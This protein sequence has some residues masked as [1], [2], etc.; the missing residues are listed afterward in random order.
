MTFLTVSK[1]IQ[2]SIAFWVSL[3][4][5]L[6]VFNFFRYVQ[7]GKR[8]SNIRCILLCV[9]NFVLLEILLQHIEGEMYCKIVL[10]LWALLL[11]ILLFT[12]FAIAEHYRVAMWDRTHISATSIKEALDALPTGLCYALPEG[13]PL[14]VNEKME[15]LGKKLLGRPLLD[16][17]AF[18]AALTEGMAMGLIQSGP[19]PIYEL[20]DG[21][22]YSFRREELRLK[23]GLVYL[24]QAT[25]VTEEYEKTKELA[26]KQKKAAVINA[27]LKSLLDTIEYVTMNR[28]L[29]QL[30]VALHDNLG[31]S[32][33]SAKRYVLN[34]DSVNPKDLL[35]IWKHNLSHLIGESPEEWQVPYYVARKEAATLGVDLQIVGT[36]P[37]EERY[38]PVI[39]QAI[40]THVINVLRHADGHVA[41]VHIW[42]DAKQYTITFTNDGNPPTGKIKETGGLGNIKRE[43]EALGGSL[44]LS[45]N[46]R[47][48][49][50]ICLPM[51]EKQSAKLA[52]EL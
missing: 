5:M 25:N 6:L 35:A 48:E 52:D 37:E 45:A 39:D 18:W 7:I 43:V 42:E 11:I 24:I 44:T 51:Q 33:L 23:E 8:R 27:R 28:E 29:L 50:I 26:E 36:L 20:S 34:P 31:R 46:P 14:L 47:F 16:A 41:M 21:S 15:A 19:E 12:V 1:V 9:L 2:G 32:L 4:E 13:L 22:V 30:K 38:L 10:P 3:V 17:G 40:S 49:M